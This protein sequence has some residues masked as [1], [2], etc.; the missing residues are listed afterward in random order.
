MKINCWEFHRCGREPGGAEVV[1]F[2][3]CPAVISKEYHGK[4]GGVNGGRYC[5]RITGTLCDILTKKNRAEKI[6]K[7]VACAFYKRVQDEQGSS[8]EM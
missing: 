1:K 7:C 2:G 6:L 5:W 8:V 4:N 3:V